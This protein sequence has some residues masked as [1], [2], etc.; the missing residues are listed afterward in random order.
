M[1]RF[2][3]RLIAYRCTHAHEL[4]AASDI[5][6]KVCTHPKLGGVCAGAKPI[7]EQIVHTLL[8][9]PRVVGERLKCVIT[10][11]RNACAVAEACVREACGVSTFLPNK[12]PYCIT[13]KLF[14]T[15]RDG[16]AK[17]AS[18]CER[19]ADGQ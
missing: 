8:G 11:K 19:D 6:E 17:G 15:Q 2:R 16:V 3:R 5:L 1:W 9:K 13:R 4:T 10:R 18:V 12:E 7:Q 14:S